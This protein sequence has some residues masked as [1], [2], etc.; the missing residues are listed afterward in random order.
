MN[1]FESLFGRGEKRREDR[2]PE[3]LFDNEFV[4]NLNY[5]DLAKG[6]LQQMLSYSVRSSDDQITNL[7]SAW[8]NYVVTN[9]QTVLLLEKDL[10]RSF[11]TLPEAYKTF[12]LKKFFFNPLKVEIFKLASLENATGN[13]HSIIQVN[14]MPFLNIYQEPDDK[15]YMFR[16]LT[17]LDPGENMMEYVA[18]SWLREFGVCVDGVPSSK[19][20]Q[21]ELI[22]KT[23]RALMVFKQACANLADFQRE[24]RDAVTASGG[25]VYGSRANL[26]HEF[27]N[28]LNITHII[29]SKIVGALEFNKYLLD[30]EDAWQALATENLQRVQK[31]EFFADFLATKSFA[32]L[33]KG[34]LDGFYAQ[35]E[36][37]DYKKY[38][39]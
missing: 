35:L 31:V 30:A 7:F 39:N 2:E 36:G 38:F 16:P 28:F 20:S 22:L 33:P 29:L 37:V 1:L 23:A 13:N 25:D 11:G 15:F 8:P 24:S 10:V 17:N 19:K 32:N 9:F 3:Y 12:S 21:K 18:L 27:S 34:V 4:S 14:L 6:F 26:L 5:S